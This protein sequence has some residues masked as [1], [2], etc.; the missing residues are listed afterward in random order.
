MVLPDA[1]EDAKEEQIPHHPSRAYDQE[2]STHSE[3]AETMEPEKVET[4][5]FVEG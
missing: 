1:E 2:D 3:Y 4:V 5:V